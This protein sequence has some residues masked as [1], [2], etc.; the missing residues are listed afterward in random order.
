MNFGQGDYQVDGLTRIVI[1]AAEV[2]EKLGGVVRGNPELLLTGFQPLHVAGGT[3][4]SFLYLSKYR[5]AALDS[6]AGAIIVNR[7]V[8][9]G[10]RTLIEVGDARE[11]YGKAIDIFYPEAARPSGVSPRAIVDETATLGPGVYVG[12]GAIVGAGAVIEDGA[13]VLA[14]AVVGEGCRV[15]RDS[16]IYYGA[17]LYPGVVLGERVTVHANAVLGVE[18]FSFRRTPDGRLRRIR[19]I[20]R[21]VVEDDVEVG[22]CACVD[23]GTLAETRIGRGSK[24]DKL[25]LIA[26]NA[27]LGPDCV[28]VGQTAVAG[29][30]RVGGGS[31]M[32]GQSAARE[33]VALGERTTVLARAFVTQDT[34]PDSVYAGSPAMPAARW[35]RVVALTK[36]LPEIVGAARKRQAA[37]D[38]R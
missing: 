27:E 23:R 7:G 30:T 16:T 4:L 14:G 37:D 2:A 22:A 10:E 1:T 13:A 17:V 19:Q 35:R 24:M 15:G 31:T 21:L 38:T 26:H 29:S 36:R 34:P 20:G 32:G 8:A 18:G 6:R 11:A 25:V 5:G 28:I 33:H 12:P 9:L 3:D